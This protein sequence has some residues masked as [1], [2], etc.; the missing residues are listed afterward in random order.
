MGIRRDINAL[1]EEFVASLLDKGREIEGLIAEVS[2]LH[3]RV[4]VLD[5]KLDDAEAHDRRD[6]L[7][8]MGENLPPAV[9]GET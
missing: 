2:E 1:R 4:D 3:K 9:S 6:M 7:V 8:F 5:D